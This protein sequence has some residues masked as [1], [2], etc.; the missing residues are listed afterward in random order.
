MKRGTSK[1]K[2]TELV[3]KLLAADRDQTLLDR[4]IS[5][6]WI[7]FRTNTNKDV[8]HK[9]GYTHEIKGGRGTVKGGIKKG[10]NYCVWRM[11]IGVGRGGFGLSLGRVSM[12][13]GVGPE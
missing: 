6:F 12:I 13:G 5:K 10:A 8:N 9:P 3:V 7:A 1:L 4:T 2:K 11:G